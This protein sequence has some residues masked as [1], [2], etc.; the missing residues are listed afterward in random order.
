[1]YLPM[2]RLLARLVARLILLLL[3]LRNRQAQLKE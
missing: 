2:T 3:L 1:L